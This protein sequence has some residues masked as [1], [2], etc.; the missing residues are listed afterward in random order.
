MSAAAGIVA[1]GLDKLGYEYIN[2]DDCWS[3]ETRDAN[4][5]LQPVGPSVLLP[6]DDLLAVAGSAALPERTRVS[7]RCGARHSTR[8]DCVQ[9]TSTTWG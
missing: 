8:T 4:G 5:N 6:V 2:M 7:G 3:A 9:T 1:Q